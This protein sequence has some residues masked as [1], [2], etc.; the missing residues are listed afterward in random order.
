MGVVWVPRRNAAGAASLE[1]RQLRPI[2]TIKRTELVSRP[3]L[4]GVTVAHFGENLWTTRV[5]IVLLL[6]E[7]V[8]SFSEEYCRVVG[9]RSGHDKRRLAKRF[10]CSLLFS[11]V[12]LAFP[13]CPLKCSLLAACVLIKVKMSTCGRKNKR[14][15]MPLL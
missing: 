1:R 3:V 4:L 9:L 14:R 8:H 10:S 13:L 12:V 5:V 11:T 7:A 15:V 2:R 6:S